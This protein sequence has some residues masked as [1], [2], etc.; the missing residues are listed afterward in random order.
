MGTGPPP[1]AALSMLQPEGVVGGG[2]KSNIA[3]M[4]G[5]KKARRE[6]EAGEEAGRPRQEAERRWHVMSFQANSPTG[7]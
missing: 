4:K 7:V 2:G 3:L 6:R 1:P 5:A